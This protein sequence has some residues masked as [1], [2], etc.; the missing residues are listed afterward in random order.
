[1]ET[2]E[3]KEKFFE[4]TTYKIERKDEKKESCVFYVRGYIDSI[5]AAKKVVAQIKNCDT[6]T[7]SFDLLF[8]TIESVKELY[9]IK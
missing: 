7:V 3:N 5:T 1:M 8:K 6:N 4:V 2:K 9:F